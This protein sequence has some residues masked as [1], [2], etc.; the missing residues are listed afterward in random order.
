MTA[1]SL[2]T[3]DLLAA[4]ASGGSEALEGV[5][6]TDDTRLEAS[7]LEPR[8]VALVRLAALFALD[9][10]PASYADQVASAIEAGA[11]AG[12]IAGVLLAVAPQIGTA[13]VVAAA[14]ELILGLG[15]DLPELAE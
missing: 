6:V 12:E 3:H 2:E 13:R 8:V 5:L 10:P 11:D 7:G 15:M 1:G 9:G 14:P 4:L